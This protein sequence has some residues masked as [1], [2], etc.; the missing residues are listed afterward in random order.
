MVPYYYV[1]IVFSRVRI[2]VE[3]ESQALRKHKT[4]KMARIKFQNGQNGVIL[5]RI[6]PKFSEKCVGTSFE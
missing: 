4:D 2:C 6:L 1:S 5:Y 3:P